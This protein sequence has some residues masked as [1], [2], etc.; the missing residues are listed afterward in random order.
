MKKTELQIED[1]VDRRGDIIR[2]FG[3]DINGIVSFEDGKTCHA[4]WLKPL[5]LTREILLKNKIANFDDMPISADDPLEELYN[6]FFEEDE[7][8]DLEISYSDYN[9]CFA[10]T[11]S[12]D[13]YSIIPLRYVHELQHAISL[14][15]IE[16]TIYV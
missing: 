6:L 1:W 2:V 12:C 16:K 15:G 5:P 3:V 10:W 11:I 13:E 7:E 8:H 14:C 4:S 9:K